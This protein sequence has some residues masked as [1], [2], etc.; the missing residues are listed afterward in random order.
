MASIKTKFAVGLFVAIGLLMTVVAILWLG[1]SSYLDK[2][3]R[4]VAYFDESVQGLS[5]DSPVKYRGVPVGKVEFVRVAPDAKLIEVVIRFEQKLKAEEHIENIV[6]QLK[7]IGITGIMF[8]EL[9][10]KDK[11]EPARLLKLT[12]QPDFPII[13]T[14]PS[15]IAKIIQGLEDV[16]KQFQA[17]DL[18]EISGKLQVTLDNINQTVTDARI[19]DISAGIR[20]SLGKV[21]KMLSGTDSGQLTDIV[22]KTASSLDRLISNADRTIQRID[23][24]IANNESGIKTS[25]DSF[26]HTMQD[27]NQAVMK[28]DRILVNNEGS[29]KE[30]I[31]NFS[32]AMKS[33]D[34][35]VARFDAIFADSE[36]K[37]QEALQD[38]THAAKNADRFML[39]GSGVMENVDNTLS[40][41]QLQLLVTAQ[42]LKKASENLS[43]LIEIVT[44]QP[45]QLIFGEPLP[46]RKL[47]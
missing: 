33:A 44:D 27:A 42:N 32:L 43:S 34:S 4:Y 37:I 1:M 3:Q 47:E 35:A 29:F 41:L 14:R 16:I 13:A 26:K 38:V 23:G 17:L 19:K 10:Q 12:F 5:K 8:I 11:S 40:N 18:K 22:G 2:G 25:I 39:K 9:D 46:A 21:D 20:S 30:A 15:G 24:L 45:S 6:A 7:T 36:N 28:L 31:H